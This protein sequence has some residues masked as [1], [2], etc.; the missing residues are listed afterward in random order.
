[1][2]NRRFNTQVAQPRKA[3]AKGGKAWWKISCQIRNEQIQVFLNYL[4]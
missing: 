3:L 4:M 2:A 1:M